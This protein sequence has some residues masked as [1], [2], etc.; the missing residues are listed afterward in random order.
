MYVYI[1]IYVYFLSD[2][3]I[4]ITCFRQTRE[5]Y[6]GIWA[7]NLRIISH[8]FNRFVSLNFVCQHNF[9]KELNFAGREIFSPSSQTLLR[10]TELVFVFRYLT[11]LFYVH[12]LCNIKLK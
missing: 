4:G 10:K 7:K 5:K 6:R 12:W 9:K 11:T 2:L 1:Y 3:H 8:I